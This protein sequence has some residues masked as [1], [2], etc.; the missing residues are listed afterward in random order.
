VIASEDRVFVELPNR[1]KGW[2]RIGIVATLLLAS[3]ALAAC[4]SAKNDPLMS[5]APSL[6]TTIDPV[7]TASIQA[8]EPDREAITSALET[9]E[10]G[11]GPDQSLALA[12]SSVETGNSGTITAIEKAT[13]A[14]GRKCYRFLSTL[15]SFTGI[16]LYDGEAC[17]LTAGQL[18]LS[19]FKSKNPA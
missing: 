7:I 12:W 14:E 13:T 9:I 16:S 8:Q 3:V 15:E 4:T 10:S 1:P 6:E 11:N 5:A 18:V 17:E 2:S 19:F